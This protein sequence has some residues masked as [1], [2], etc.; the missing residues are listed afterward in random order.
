MAALCWAENGSSKAGA[1]DVRVAHPWCCRRRPPPVRRSVAPWEKDFCE[2]CG[3]P[4]RKV[5]DR[6]AGLNAEGP[7][8][9]VAR[10]D[11][12]GAVKALLASRKRY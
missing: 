4:W 1:H 10:W 6:W 12:S 9:R 7:D 3:V 5:T 2:S 11:D 8:G